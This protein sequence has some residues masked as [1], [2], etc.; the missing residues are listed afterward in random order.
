MASLN[1]RKYNQAIVQAEL[2]GHTSFQGPP[3]KV[4]PSH[5]DGAGMTVRDT[6]RRSCL[7]CETARRELRATKETIKRA[8]K[9]AAKEAE[10]RAAKE[11]QATRSVALCRSATTEAERWGLV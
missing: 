7:L 4:D 1:R 8:E 3:C 9:R 5:I 2:A 11:A 10:R 6:M